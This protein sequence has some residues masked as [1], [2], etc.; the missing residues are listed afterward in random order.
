MGD[1][2]NQ[3]DHYK[4][5]GIET[6][7]YIK[8]KLTPEMW[9]GYL[10]GNVIKYTSRYQHKNMVE[11][12]EKADVYLGWLLKQVAARAVQGVIEEKPVPKP[13]MSEPVEWKDPFKLE[14]NKCPYC[15]Q[16]LKGKY[17]IHL[18]MYHSAV[19]QDMLKGR[20]IDERV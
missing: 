11:D 12:L 10:L 15:G 3:P 1:N 7:D 2:V 18:N 5:G 6:I 14:G 16:T 9:E 13:E 4:A 19:Y 17:W 8:A 20:A